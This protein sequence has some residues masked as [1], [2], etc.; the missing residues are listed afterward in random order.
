VSLFSDY[1][2][3]SLYLQTYYIHSRYV[4]RLRQLSFSFGCHVEAKKNHF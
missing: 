2:L 1:S 4:V 3:R